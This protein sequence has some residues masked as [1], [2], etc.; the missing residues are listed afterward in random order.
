MLRNKWEV[1][2]AVHQRGVSW[3]EP[4][5]EAVAEKRGCH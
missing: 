3:K 2:T 4:R 5:N 1:G